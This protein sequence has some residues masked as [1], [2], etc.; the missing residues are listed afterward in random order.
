MSDVEFNTKELDQ[1]SKDLL[2]LAQQIKGKQSRK[3]MRKEGKK[4]AR[5]QR[6][7]FKSCNIGTGEGD[8]KDVEK[9]FKGG[10]VFKKDGDLAV[11]GYS[12]HPLTHLLEDGHII[13]NKKDGPE[14]GFVLGWH[15]VD[16]A[17]RKFENIYVDDTEIFIDELLQEHNL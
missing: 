12:S 3:F 15:F 13:K 7:E 4:L 17:A 1:F 2:S 6:R 5:E 16:K 11:R 14:L 8:T 10:K 9:S